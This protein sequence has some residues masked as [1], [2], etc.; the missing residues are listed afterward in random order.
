VPEASA[1]KV[2]LSCRKPVSQYAPNS[3]AALIVAALGDEILHRMSLSDA[4]RRIA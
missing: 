2:A 4:Q 3:K 1:F